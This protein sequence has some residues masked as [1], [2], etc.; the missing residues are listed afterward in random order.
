MTHELCLFFTLDLYLFIY[1]FI[2]LSIHSFIHLF[3][4]LFIYLFIYIYSLLLFPAAI[5]FLM[6]SLRVCN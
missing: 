4:Y 5:D 3:T 6:T 2:Y 1:L